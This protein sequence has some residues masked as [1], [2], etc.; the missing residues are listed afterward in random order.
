M[1]FRLSGITLPITVDV[2]VEGQLLIFL[3]RA[4]GEN[5][6]SDAIP[7]ITLGD[8]AIRLTTVVRESAYPTFLCGVDE[9]KGPT[10]K[11]L[12]I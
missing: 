4:F 11:M 9:L 2:V 5:P 1:T 8:I 10:S 7:D 12:C 6:H 3:D